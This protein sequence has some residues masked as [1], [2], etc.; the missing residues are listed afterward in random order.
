MVPVYCYCFVQ[1]VYLFFEIIFLIF[2][3]RSAMKRCPLTTIFWNQ[4]K[5]IGAEFKLITESPI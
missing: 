3:Q 5:Q 4:I 1:K 2:F